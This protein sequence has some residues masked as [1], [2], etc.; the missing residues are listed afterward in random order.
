[1]AISPEFTLFY[2]GK[3]LCSFFYTHNELGNY[4]FL[5]SLINIC[6]FFFR[7]MF[8]SSEMCTQCAI[9]FDI[10]A[11]NNESRGGFAR[12]TKAICISVIY[13]GLAQTRSRER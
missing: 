7:E 2:L 13:H 5:T 11:K 4:E 8:Y 1:M 6:I 3:I 12:R 9:S 10:N